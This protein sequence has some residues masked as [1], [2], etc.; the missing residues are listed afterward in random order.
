MPNVS[1]HLLI[2]LGL[3]LSA[4]SPSLGQ[5][6]ASA[7]APFDA[8]VRG[9]TA[10]VSFTVPSKARYSFYLDLYFQDGDARDP[11]RRE[12]RARVGALAGSGAYDSNTMRRRDN[13]VPIPVRLTV[14]RI[15]GADRDI[16][17]SEVFREHVREGFTANYFSKLIVRR[18]LTEGRYRAK[19]E[20]LEDVPSLRTTPIRFDVHVA[21]DRS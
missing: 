7:Q 6:H 1:A 4:T 20:A 5:E 18:E 17:F 9:A 19:I 3:T 8:G 11:D 16:V 2:V 10:E 13:G 12:D 14:T 15:G 21:F